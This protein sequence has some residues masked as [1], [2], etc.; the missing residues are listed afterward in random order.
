M[1]VAY[2]G[3]PRVTSLLC[4]VVLR[5]RVMNNGRAHVQCKFIVFASV[6]IPNKFCTLPACRTPPFR[7]TYI[8]CTDHHRQHVCS[9]LSL[10]L[11][12]IISNTRHN[13]LYAKIEI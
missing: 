7:Y 11:T 1:Y 12:I 2:N 8:N 9:Y 5:A 4:Q 3:S 13:K 10:S 6:V